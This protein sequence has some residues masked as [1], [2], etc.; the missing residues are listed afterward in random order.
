MVQPEFQGQQRWIRSR[1]VR[2]RYYV[3]N[4]Y[5]RP[6]VGSKV[7]YYDP[8]EEAY[9]DANTPREGTS[10]YLEL[11]ALDLED[12]PAIERFTSRWGLLGLCQ[13]RLLQHRRVMTDEDRDEVI[14]DTPPEW[15]TEEQ[16]SSASSAIA[17][18][19]RRRGAARRRKTR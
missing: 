4:G 5:I 8:F 18:G 17:T 1:W 11:I 6:V 16:F 10:L 15:V 12:I 7:E 19:A 2:R 9:F 13:H 3:E 14:A